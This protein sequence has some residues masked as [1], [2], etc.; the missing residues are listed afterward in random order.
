MAAVLGAGLEGIEN[1][2]ELKIKECS[3]EKSA[4]LLASE[5]RAALGITER[6]PLSWTE[7]R[8]NFEK[9]E[10]VD[11]LFG[12]DF[13]KKYLAVNKACSLFLNGCA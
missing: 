10:L 1:G 5:G 8:V 3:G 13:K 9:S 12:A 11:A 2:K 7:A 6:L 4:A